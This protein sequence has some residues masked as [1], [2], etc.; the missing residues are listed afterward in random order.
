MNKTIPPHFSR[1]LAC[2]GAGLFFFY[3]IFQKVTFNAISTHLIAHFHLTNTGLG[4][5]S[6]AYLYANALWLIPGG[7]LL[8]R[9]SSRMVTLL[10]MFACVASSFIFAES[11]SLFLDVILRFIGGFGSAMSLLISLRLATNWFPNQTARVI[12]LLVSLGMSAGI[13]A[14]KYTKWIR[15]ICCKYMWSFMPSDISNSINISFIYFF[16]V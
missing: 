4:A 15:I 8:E 9:F 16:I 3:T 1:I 11:S 6:S 7:I 10:F 12:G 2:I 5:V 14:S 13:V